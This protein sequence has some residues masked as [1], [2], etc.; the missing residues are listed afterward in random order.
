VCA[1]LT[2]H[3]EYKHEHILIDDDVVAFLS[4]Y[5]TLLGYTI[6]APRAHI[7]DVTGDRKLLRRVVDVV[8]DV[9][10]ALK[11]TLPTE[12]VYLMSL[13]SHQGNATCTGTSRPARGALRAAAVPRSDGGKWGSRSHAGTTGN[14][15]GEDTLRATSSDEVIGL[16][17]ERTRQVRLIPNEPAMIDADLRSDRAT[18]GSARI[19]AVLCNHHEPHASRMVR[20]HHL[21][22][23]SFSR[24]APR[25]R[26]A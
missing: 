10:E 15:G 22:R 5:P 2:G 7:V 20:T 3:S 4:R 1:Y 9:A 13:G 25:K 19:V 16:A 18:N 17:A 11:S 6:V 26:K 23:P 24:S 21:N 12:R 8:H 14:S